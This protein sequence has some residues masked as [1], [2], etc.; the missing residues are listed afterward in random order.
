MKVKKVLFFLLAFSA[1]IACESEKKR[2]LP[3]IGNYDLTYRKVD[4]Q[5]VVDTVYPKIPTFRFL[6]EDSVWVTNKDFKNKIWVA[7]FF[8]A[9]C[10]TIC[11]IMNSQLKNLNKETASL[12][13]HVQFLSFTINPKNDVP[14][15]LKAY[16][17]KHGII[18]KNWAFLTGEE[19]ETHRLGIENFQT[20]AGRDEEAE[21]GYAHSG[22]FTLVDKSGYVRGVYAVTSF[23]GSVNKK[24]YKRL[25]EDIFKLLEYEYDIS[26]TK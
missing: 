4:G 17:K 10:P 18:A 25:K 3:I 16:R 21:G 2:V 9:T 11:P 20:F 19:A 1:L 26:P 13:K 24:E 14:S 23:D 15:V 7:E 6:N 12:K 8:F 5:T 22:S